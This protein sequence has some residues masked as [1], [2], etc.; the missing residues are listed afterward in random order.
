M[1]SRCRMPEESIKASTGGTVTVAR[2]QSEEL[3]YSQRPVVT[4]ACPSSALLPP[5]GR[6]ARPQEGHKLK[7]NTGRGSGKEGKAEEAYKGKAFAL[8]SYPQKT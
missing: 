6:L 1:P 7:F 2:Q 3:Q 4:V 8:K 5:P